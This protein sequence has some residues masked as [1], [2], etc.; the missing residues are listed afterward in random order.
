M[1]HDARE[2]DLLFFQLRDELIIRGIATGFTDKQIFDCCVYYIFVRDEFASKIPDVNICLP[3]VMEYIK[4]SGIN[5]ADTVTPID[6]CYYLIFV[7]N[8][9]LTHSEDLMSFFKQHSCRVDIDDGHISPS[10]CK[11][12]RQHRCQRRG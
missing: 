5:I 8:M 2:V 10:C 3:R 12:R 9:G 6:F 11:C 1:K 7:R 4:E